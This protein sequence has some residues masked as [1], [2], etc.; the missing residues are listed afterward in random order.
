M[1]LRTQG[2]MASFRTCIR[3]AGA[4]NSSAPRLDGLFRA[5]S[6]SMREV[7]WDCPELARDRAAFLLVQDGKLHRALL[8]RPQ[9]ISQALLQHPALLDVLMKALEKVAQSLKP[10]AGPADGGEGSMAVHY[11]MNYLLLGDQDDEEEE[12]DDDEEVMERRA[13]QPAS[14]PLTRDQLSA[15]LASAIHSTSQPA[16]AAP[17]ADEQRVS[18]GS[19]L[20]SSYD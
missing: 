8:H 20:A 17:D 1:A 12:D 18:P 3:L 15:A 2:L 4:A 11:D 5:L 7:S 13:R 14:A 9:S 6:E 10:N 16:A 19:G